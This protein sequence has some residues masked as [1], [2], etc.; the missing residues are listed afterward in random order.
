MTIQK[1]KLIKIEIKS[2]WELVQTL[3]KITLLAHRM[4]YLVFTCPNSQKLTKSK[5]T[6]SWEMVRTLLR[7]TRLEHRKSYLVI[8]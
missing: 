6:S 5:I 8:I 1:K 4:L 7:I 3:L 2:S